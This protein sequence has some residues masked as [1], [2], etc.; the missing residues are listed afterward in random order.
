MFEEPTNRLLIDG[1]SRFRRLGLRI[2]APFGFSLATQREHT[3]PQRNRW[4]LPLVLLSSSAALFIDSIAQGLGRLGSWVGVPLLWAALTVLYIPPVTCLYRK[5]LHRTDRIAVIAVI[6]F[7]VY[8]FKVLHS[9]TALSNFDEFLHWVTLADMLSSQKLFS[10]NSLLPVSPLYPGLELVT[11]CLIKIANIDL[12]LGAVIIVGLARIVEPILLFLFYEKISGSPRFASI[13]AI[14][15]FGDAA[16]FFF[17]AQYAY[18]SLAFMLFCGSLLLT[19]MYSKTGYSDKRLLVGLLLIILATTVTHHL[20][21]YF[22]ALFLSATVIFD[23]FSA[24]KPKHWERGL[25]LAG[26]SA[27][28]PAM[29][30]WLVQAPTASYLG[31]VISG[32]LSEFALM[33]TGESK[34]AGFFKELPGLTNPFYL[35]ALAFAS[36]ILISLGLSTGF[37]RALSLSMTMPWNRPPYADGR[38]RFFPI[39]RVAPL[40]TIALSTL[41][42][43][44]TVALRLTSSGWE[45]GSRIGPFTF[46]G[47]AAVSAVSI[48]YYWDQ[49]PSF[50]RRVL[51]PAALLIVLLGGAVAGWGVKA[52]RS[53]YFVSAD[54]QSVEQAGIAA[55]EWTRQWLGPGHRFASDR[56]N[57]VLLA[58][59]GQQDIVTSLEEGVDVSSV[60]FKKW[61]W[62]E[63]TLLRSL[64]VEFLLVDRRLSRSLPM[65][66][67]YYE[68]GVTEPAGIPKLSDLLKYDGLRGVS[69]IYD[70]GHIVIYDVR[71]IGFN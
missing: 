43:P 33:L 47:V 54:A 12:F 16:F 30:A 38:R 45:L 2:C 22:L 34:S 20:T 26:L 28:S 19:T 48:V 37:L 32:G 68:G 7:F 14:A 57:R 46:I 39:V 36:T 58:T 10:S 23:R 59:Y 3:A 52:A 63:Y 49:F 1:S 6:A 71:H 11:D 62:N 29:W 69:R 31:P 64:N 61:S 51:G 24:I 35:R 50:V 4:I 65:M 25:V 21:S 66:G 17:H 27:I 8:M 41:I 55:S 44:V 5:Q 70:N 15:Y 60:F 40:L 67:V 56:V 18:E 53:P 9:P 42:F 13:A